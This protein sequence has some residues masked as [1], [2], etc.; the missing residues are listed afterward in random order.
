MSGRLVRVAAIVVGFA[1]A[2]ASPASAGWLITPFI[3]TTFK[4]AT[5]I[6]NVEPGAGSKKVTIGGSAGFLTD[7]IFGAEVNAS[8]AFRFFTGDNPST[9]VHSG[10]T[11]LMGDAVFAVPLAITHESLRPYAVAGAGLI[12][13]STTDLISFQPV[14]RNLTGMEIG[15]GAIGFVTRRAGFRFDVRRISSLTR[16]PA[17]LPRFGGSRLS[18]WRL[19]VGVIVRP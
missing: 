5:N 10:V 2:V 6:V 19:S 9:T 15:A 11:T 12:H 14:S 13:A 7:G 1:C 18:Y 8:H 4:L 16:E 3:G 17:T